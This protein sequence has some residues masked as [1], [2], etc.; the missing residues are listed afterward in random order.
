MYWEVIN[1][2][3]YFALKGYDSAKFWGATKRFVGMVVVPVYMQ[4]I[5]RRSM[6]EREVCGLIEEAADAADAA[7]QEN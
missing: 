1:N 3:L 2:Y 5:P 4:D 7:E 6:V